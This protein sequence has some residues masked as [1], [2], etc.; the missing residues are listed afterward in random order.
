[1]ADVAFFF[2]GFVLG[3]YGGFV[4]KKNNK[5]LLPQ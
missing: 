5:R 1:M 2:V 4:L 3:T